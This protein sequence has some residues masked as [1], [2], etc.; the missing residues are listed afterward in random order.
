MAKGASSSPKGGESAAAP[1]GLSLAGQLDHYGWRG[2]YT[3]VSAALAG[4]M[5][6]GFPMAMKE[7]WPQY[8][9]LIGADEH[10]DS[11]FAFAINA[12]VWSLAVFWIGNGVMYLVYKY[13][14]AFM[15]PYRVSDSWPWKGSAKRQAEWYLL[16]LKTLA[17]LFVN[18]VLIALPTAYFMGDFAR[19][20]GF[21]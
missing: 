20:L 4:L 19:A 15:E 9:A 6:V 14:P 10:P 12:A 1:S 17:Q 16:L 18:Q 8:L 3:L 21:S 13:E 11:N 5:L 7:V 2:G